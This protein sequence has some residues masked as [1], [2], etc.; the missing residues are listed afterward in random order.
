[1]KGVKYKSK[2]SEID[3]Q[4]KKGQRSTRPV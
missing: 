1:L 4:Q 2:T 3:Q